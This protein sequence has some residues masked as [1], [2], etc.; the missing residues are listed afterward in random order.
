MHMVKE[1]EKVEGLGFFLVMRIDNI[2]R[3][4]EF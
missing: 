4:K 2:K 3:V 1:D